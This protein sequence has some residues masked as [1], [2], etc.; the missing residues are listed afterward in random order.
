V[1]ALV[2]CAPA[3]AADGQK[4]VKVT[5]PQAQAAGA[6][7]VI[8]VQPQKAAARKAALRKGLV[9]TRALTRRVSVDRRDGPELAYGGGVLSVKSSAALVIGL[10]DGST[11]YAKNTK[12]VVPIASITKLMTAMVVLD[13]G[14]PLD[15]RVV[16]ETADLDFLKHTHSRLGVG[17]GLSRAEMLQLALMSS[18]NRAAAALGRAYPG[19]SEAFIAAMNRKAVELG[20]FNTRFVDPTG[21]SSENVSTA[22]DLVKMVK[23]AYQYPMIRASTTAQAHEV[24]SLT[25]R[26]LQYRNSNGL[27]KNP[28]WEIGLSKTGYINEAGRC[29]V[30]QAIIAARP[31]VIV[32]LD[33]WGKHTRIGD[34]NRIKKWMESYSGRKSG[35]VSARGAGD[36]PG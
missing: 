25:G 36:S 29:L 18:E 22:E 33:S 12:A 27:V 17:T 2:L 26:S 13:A 3:H 10:D 23:S 28:T 32:L 9:V 24:A 5:Y 19:G 4:R 1:L 7:R 14:L 35:I 30:M 34:A 15:E 16:I 11:L 20:M 31:V 8:V 6:K 21:L